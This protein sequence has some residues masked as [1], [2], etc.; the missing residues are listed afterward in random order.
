[1]IKYQLPYTRFDQISD[2]EHEKYLYGKL[3][4]KLLAEA[5]NKTTEFMF[6]KTGRFVFSWLWF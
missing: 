2:H 4:T 1:M 6:T 5:A 3:F